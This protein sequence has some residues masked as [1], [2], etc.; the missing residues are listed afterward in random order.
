MSVSPIT[1]MC[2]VVLAVMCAVPLV[3]WGNPYPRQIFSYWLGGTGAA[4]AFAALT[5][6]FPALKLSRPVEFLIN[7]IARLPVR[8]FSAGVACFSSLLGAYFAVAT[9]NRGASTTDELAQLFHARILLTGRWYLPVDINREFFAL[10]TV[11]D[12]VH[13][14]SQFPIGGPLLL[15]L[16]DV[17]GAPWIINPILMG[18]AT[19]AMY[20]FGRR[21][22]GD[23]VGRTIA[24]V[25]A[26]APSIVIMSGTMMNHMP[27]LCLATIALALLA[28]WQESESSRRSMLLAAGIGTSMGLM[29]T[30]RPLDAVVVATV[31]GIFQLSVFRRTPRRIVDWLPQALGGVVGASPV[32]LANAATTGNPFRFAYELNWGAGHGLGFHTDP[33]GNAF[34]AG[35]G[36][37]HIITY[38]SE[39]NMFVTAWPV[40]VVLLVIVSL[41]LIRNATKWDSLLLGVFFAQL[42]VHGAYWGRGE[43]FWARGFSL[44]RCPRLWC[45]SHGCRIC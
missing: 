27:T 8:I 3:F 7:W 18:V 24:V 11:V 36:L 20:Q 16:G 28:A 41:L 13:W 12:R 15:A 38:V 9:F 37:E 21:A 39:L 2:A 17:F 32:L 34:T 23:A 4:F 43:C 35:M 22:Y 33:Y 26:T 40:P 30:L 14:Y 29:A 42:F 19:F 5:F 6:L 45:S 25:F 44:P 1:A 31:T 10:D